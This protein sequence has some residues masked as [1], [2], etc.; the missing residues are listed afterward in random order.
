MAPGAIVV[1]PRGAALEHSALIGAAGNGPSAP[2][3]TVAAA[4]CA[5]LVRS[6]VLHE[7]GVVALALAPSAI[8]AAASG[9]ALLPGGGVCAP[10]GA[11]AVAVRGAALE[12]SAIASAAGSVLAPGAVVVAARGAALVP[13][14][15]V[16][17]AGGTA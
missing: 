2:G 11:V 13:S 16:E 4:V 14:V 15:I 10:G 1:A 5:V 8:V 3:A 17:A 12:L 7:P 6:L 9:A